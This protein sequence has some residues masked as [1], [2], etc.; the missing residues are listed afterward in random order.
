[1]VACIINSDTSNLQKIL[2]L[3]GLAGQVHDRPSRLSVFLRIDLKPYLWAQVGHVLVIHARGYQLAKTSH[4]VHLVDV[5]EVVNRRLFW[6]SDRS[7]KDHVVVIDFK[8]LLSLFH[9]CA[10]LLGSLFQAHYV[11]SKVHSSSRWKA[12]MGLNCFL[13]TPGC[14]GKATTYLILLR[15]M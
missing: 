7:I 14:N 12:D 5:I 4:R 8:V 11:N 9:T 15:W 1:M 6:A 13:A 3:Q 2:V 10:R